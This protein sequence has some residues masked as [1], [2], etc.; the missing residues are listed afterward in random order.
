MS[1]L[2]QYVID[3]FSFKEAT[4]SLIFYICFVVLPLLTVF[5]GNKFPQ[6]ATKVTGTVMRIIAAVMSVA[7]V[8]LFIKIAGSGEPIEGSTQKN[9]D[10]ESIGLSIQISLFAIYCGFGFIIGY[11]L[12]NLFSNIRKAIPGII[13]IAA[14]IL[15]WVVAYA[16]ADGSMGDAQQQA[17][18]IEK[19]ITEQDS[20]D[21][22]A[23]LIATLILSIL[24]VGLTF[25]G[26][27]VRIF[28]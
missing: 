21:A 28:R 16:M 12:L 10:Q 4:L 1:H 17:E 8:F 13:G 27:I 11:S 7:A 24:A 18:W 23:G 14:F 25:I 3:I 26:E 19:G 9:W 2:A 22:S 15:I 6:Q 5:I 20:V